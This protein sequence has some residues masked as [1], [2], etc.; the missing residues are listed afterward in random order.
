MSV[1]N[2]FANATTAIPLVQLDQNFNTGITL[3]NTTVYLGNTTTSFG[4]V[5]LTGAAVNGTVGATTPAAGK[6]TT[7]NS[8]ATGNLS[9]Q[10]N[11]S[12]VVAVTSSGAAVTGTLSASGIISTSGTAVITSGNALQSL[13]P[14]QV[15]AAN[16]AAVSQEAS[17][18]VV[19]A[20]GTDTSTYGT[21][22]LQQAFSNGGQVSRLTI[23]AGGSIS[24]GTSAEV[25]GA[26]TP[27]TDNTYTLGAA[28]K[29]W[30][31]VYATTGTINTSDER[32]KII[33]D[34]PVPGLSFVQAISPFFGKWKVGGNTVTQED[35]GFE[36][37]ADGSKTQKFKK[38]ITPRPG[39]RTHA[40]F[41]AQQIKAQME[42]MGL[43]WGAY[44]YSPED[45]THGLRHDQLI[46]VLWTAIQ[47]L[48]AQNKSIEARLAALENK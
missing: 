10:S 15:H 35:D 27:G 32:Q 20:Y 34:T 6:F 2:V 8:D 29:R 28:S 14:I 7:I 3:G 46:P 4:N 25:E 31:T 30:T 12:T 43:D 26:F 44:V 11:G 36:I 41:S 33:L 23:N 47:E 39:V 40:M 9:I 19:R 5:T 37:E 38:V 21:L 1:P 42:V 48:S 13:G 16:M 17:G 18:A 22:R 45:D 24:I